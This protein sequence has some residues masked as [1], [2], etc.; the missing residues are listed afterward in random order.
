MRWRTGRRSTNIE[1]RR[2][3]SMGGGGVRI[4]GC[5]GLILLLVIIL[6]GADPMAF[7]DALFG[8]GGGSP[9]PATQPVGT[10]REGDE[11]S[12]FT[13]TVLAYTE[14]TWGPIFADAGLQYRRPTVVLFTDVTQS[15][16]GY[17]SSATGPFYCPLDQ[18]VY[19][20]LGFFTDLA[21][22]VG[23][24]SN[25][26]DFAAAYVVSHEVGHHVQNLLGTS[27]AVR[28][29]QARNPSAANELSVLL[30]LQADCFAGVVWAERYQTEAVNLV[31]GDVEEGLR[32]AAA[33]GDDRLMRSAGRAV[34][35]E[36]FTH[37]S[38][39]QRRQ[40]LQRGITTGDPDACD[41]FGQAGYD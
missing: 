30:E 28:Q 4:G 2:G 31:P 29:L 26:F 15:G 9:P 18:R 40:W 22:L 32:T 6:L 24:A 20:D 36:S 39:D 38:S 34:Q 21:N 27:N 11:L 8:G 13:S 1:D 16:C 19:L 10:E 3:Q 7:L 37:G 5:M 41:T 35:P 17:G 12:E 25:E 33:I 23:L 14:D